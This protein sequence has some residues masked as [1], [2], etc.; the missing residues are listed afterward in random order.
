M[1]DLDPKLR[2]LDGIQPPDLWSS[3]EG[4]QPPRRPPPPGWHRVAA[5]V[6]ALLVGASGAGVAGIAFVASR[7]QPVDRPPSSSGIV[8]SSAVVRPG[9]RCTATVASVV[10]P[11]E[12]TG[13]RFVFENVGSTAANIDVYHGVGTFTLVA[14]DG[15]TYDTA[16][17]LQLLLGPGPLP[18]ETLPPGGTRT[19]GSNDVSVRWGGPL[20][21]HPVCQ[22][23][24]LPP[25][26]VSVAN[27]G[28]TPTE[29]DALNRSLAAAGS[30]FDGCRPGEGG[31]A[32][33]G[34]LAPPNG[35]GLNPVEAKCWASIRTHE[36]F[37]VVTLAWVSP[38]SSPPFDPPQYWF[39]TRLPPGQGPSE[40]GQ[41]TFVISAGDVRS[42]DGPVGAATAPPDLE[43][44][45]FDRDGGNWV[46]GNRGSC[47][48]GSASG[49]GIF[50][51]APTSTPC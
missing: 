11:G 51:F 46:G 40:F 45:Y 35:A 22:G 2:E 29:A 38:S 19:Y 44:V 28:P 41:W 3:I 32:V 7:N 12:F 31:A 48:G 1:A 25:L 39:D 18:P 33:I 23:K 9:L 49:G 36:G 30:V 50:F 4:G 8:S 21:I 43:V 17:P 20:T 14:A 42:V 27:P 10:R 26:D 24:K 5:A 15:A 16:R 47:G 34:V 37:T 6:V 13:L